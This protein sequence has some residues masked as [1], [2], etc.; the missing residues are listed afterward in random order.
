MYYK[1]IIIIIQ[2]SGSLFI[3]YYILLFIIIII[4]YIIIIILLI[5]LHWHFVSPPKFMHSVSCAR[6]GR[7]DW[8]TLAQEDTLPL[9]LSLLKGWGCELADTGSATV[10]ARLLCPACPLRRLFFPGSSIWDR[11]AAR[12]TFWRCLAALSLAAL[13]NVGSQG[14]GGLVAAKTMM[15]YMCTSYPHSHCDPGWLD[16]F[17]ERYYQKDVSYPLR[18]T[19][20]ALGRPQ[21][22]L[23]LGRDQLALSDGGSPRTSRTGGVSKPL[24]IADSWSSSVGGGCRTTRP[25]RRWKASSTKCRR[26]TRFAGDF[27]S[28][29]QDRLAN[30][31][32]RAL[33]P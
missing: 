6:T 10:G 28:P 27:R 25:T 2:A 22:T 29:P 30:R 3:F 21:P 24:W 31:S 1:Y 8:P 15:C 33:P 5:I 12:H 14:G 7:G 16:T 11:G 13:L 9:L 18:R 19:V 20:P 23:R 26:G 17:T 32:F 4:N